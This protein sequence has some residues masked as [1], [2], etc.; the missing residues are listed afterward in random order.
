MPTRCPS[1][2]RARPP[3]SSLTSRP[4]SAFLEVGGAVVLARG[5]PEVDA[6]LAALGRR[7]LTIDLSEFQIAGAD[8]ARRGLT[9]TRG[10]QSGAGTRLGVGRADWTSTIPAATAARP[11][12]SSGR[13][14]SWSRSAPRPSPKMGVRK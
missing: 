14:G 7:V 11:T 9:G 6:L 1:G 8:A 5:A 12:A 4:Q 3:A 10:G 13:T 2:R